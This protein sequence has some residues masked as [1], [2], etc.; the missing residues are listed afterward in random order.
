MHAGTRIIRVHRKRDDEAASEAWEFEVVYCFEE[1]GS[2]NYGSAAQPS[3]SSLKTIVSTSFYDKIMCL[4]R[5]DV[6]VESRLT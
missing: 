5:V 1:H 2:M 6:G 3:A 4:W